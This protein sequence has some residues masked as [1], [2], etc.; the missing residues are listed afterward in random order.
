MRRLN[1][2]AEWDGGFFAI[3]RSERVV[4]AHA[5]HAIQIVIAVD[6]T[7]GIRG[8]RGEWRMGN[9]VVVRPD[10]V[11]SY[12]GN[13]AVGASGLLSFGSRSFL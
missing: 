10:V 8:K 13:G 7:V 12:N 9:G 2:P 4:P 5:H 11:H 6:G 3:G 1:E